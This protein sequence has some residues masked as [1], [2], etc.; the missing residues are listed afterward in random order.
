MNGKVEPDITNRK[1]FGWLGAG[2]LITIAILFGS[3][4]MAFQ[5]LA[6]EQEHIS[7]E[8]DAMWQK[9]AKMASDITGIKVHN[10]ELK[11]DV[12]S[13]KEALKRIEIQ[14]SQILEELRRR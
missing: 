1:L 6:T 5:S 7:K 11:A 14:N 10:A 3:G 4:L 2:E 8:A 9:Q 13:N 12:K